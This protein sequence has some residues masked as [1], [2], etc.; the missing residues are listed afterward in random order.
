M[1][2]R[3]GHAFAGTGRLV[4]FGLRRDRIVLPVSVFALAVWILLYPIQYEIYY[5]TQADINAYATATAGNAALEAFLGPGR[6]I[7]TFDGLTA[8]E[9]GPVFSILASLFAMFM[10]IRHTRS[11]EEDGRTELVL[12][13]PVGRL[14]ELAAALVITGGALLLQAVLWWIGL[15]AFGLDPIGTA[16]QVLAIIGCAFVFMALTAVVIQVVSHA[17]AARGVV[18]LLIGGFYVIRAVG[19]LGDNFLSWVSPIG[20]SIATQPY[21]NPRWWVL[22]LPLVTTITLTWLGFLLLSRRDLGAGYLRP[23]PGPSTLRSHLPAPMA[24]AWRIQRGALRGWLFGLGAAALLYGTLGKE[25]E[26]LLESSPQFA[27]ALFAGGE[28]TD[29]YFATMLEFYAIVASGFVIGSALRPSTEE[30]AG[31]AELVLA[32]GVGKVRWALSH[33]LLSVFGALLLMV[34]CGALSGVGFG[35][36]GGGFDRLADLVAAGPV[37]VPAALVLGGIA[38]LSF[39]IS[40]RASFLPWSA[41][42]LCALVLT[43]QSLSAISEQ[44]VDLSPFS[45]LPLVPAQPIEIWPIA[46]LTAIAAALATAGLGLWHRRDL[47]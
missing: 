42:G 19:D 23:R 35:L 47:T 3:S 30:K 18:G 38:V 31:R 45:H 12:S 9:M 24:F 29:S 11:E 8:W 14:S 2:S 1:I 28:I 6:A 10:V 7:D 16:A 33:V 32:T 46:W 22:L 4:R 37:F 34:V 44:L 20:W 36:A 41:L 5:P 17:R 43:L 21:A 13:S 40:P 27:E 25:V 39:G 15:V 26:A